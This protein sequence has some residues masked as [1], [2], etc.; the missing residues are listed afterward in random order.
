MRE[1]HRATA[2]DDLDDDPFRGSLL[3]RYL[4][5]LLVA[6]LVL[7]PIAATVL[8]GFKDLGELRTNPF[9]LPRTWHFE[10]YWGILSSGRYWQMIFNSAV[11]ASFTTAL[12]LVAAGLAAFVFAHLRFA[13]DRYL[14]NY[15]LIGLLFPAATAILPLFIKVRDL[16]LLDTYA[17]VVLPA[18]AFSLGAAIL[19]FRNFFKQLPGELLDSALIDGATYL[20]FFARVVLPLSRPILATVGVISFVQAWN[21]YLLPLILLNSDAKYPWPLGI[22]VYQGEFSSDW[23]LV[24]AFVSLTIAPAVVVF[25]LAQRFIVA[26]LT[27]GAVKG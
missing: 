27:A 7:V 25:L 24:L 20:Q 15:F 22:M 12:V 3:P 11:I 16:G 21:N 10:N 13:G 23:Q 8:G 17:G 2:V 19:L 5:L 6:G 1:P 4:V 14:L 18:A 9:G 26:G